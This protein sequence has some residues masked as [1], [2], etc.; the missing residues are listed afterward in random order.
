METMTNTVRSI[1]S[2]DPLVLIGVVSTG[3]AVGTA[4]GTVIVTVRYIARFGPLGAIRLGMKRTIPR[5]SPTSTRTGDVHRLQDKLKHVARSRERYIVIRGPKGVGKS[6]LV[7]TALR[8]IWGVVE[9]IVPPGTKSD[10]IEQTALM[11]LSNITKPG[12]D[13]MDQSV[14]QVLGCF[15]LLSREPPVVLLRVLSRSSG[16]SYAGV[17][18]AARGLC[19]TYGLRVVIDGGRESIPDR[20]VDPQQHLV[21]DIEPMTEDVLCSVAE[22]RPLIEELKER[23]LFELVWAVMGGVPA[24]YRDMDEEWRYCGNLEKVVENSVSDALGR[25]KERISL[26]GVKNSQ[27]TPIVEMFGQEQG[28]KMEIPITCLDERGIE[29]PSK[30][31]N[32]F[33]VISRNG[34]NVLVPVDAAT[35]FVLNHNLSLVTSQSLPILKKLSCKT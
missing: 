3:A 15:G 33:R 10:S 22:F 25:A 21:M 1:A 20:D 24:N 14:G 35:S 32:V 17:S 27:M 12:Q 11:R 18:A 5:S 7:N 8:D 4:V 26:L 16:E 19:T 2:T 28:K 9:V 31:D 34:T 13:D 23:G 29:R 6:V 30:E